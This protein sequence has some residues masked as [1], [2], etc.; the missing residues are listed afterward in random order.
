MA[1]IKLIVG[2]GNPG[3]KYIKT[4]HN[5][6]FNVLDILAEK[7]GTGWKNWKDQAELSVKSGGEKILL[8]KPALFMNLSGGPVRAIL[9][10]NGITPEEMLVVSDDFSLEL[11]SIRLRLKGSSGGHNGL[12]SII[13]NLG[14]NEFPRMRLGI[15][16][17]PGRMDPADFVLSEFGSG[18]KEVLN[19][20]YGKA[21]I[22][23]EDALL[24]GVEKAA[25]K[26]PGK[27][28]EQ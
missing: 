11:G 5:A 21:V 23:A 13:M 1:N 3:K 12:E 24:A 28:R 18:E 26:I 15:G 4:R 14:T 19:E 2:L 25:S 10:Y 27:P 20:M 6:G 22:A 9:D 17:V 16:P 8:A 7:W